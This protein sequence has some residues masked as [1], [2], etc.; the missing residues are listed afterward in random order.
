MLPFAGKRLVQKKSTGVSKDY[1]FRITTSNERPIKFPQNS[2]NNLE[3][4]WE[5]VDATMWIHTGIY[6]STRRSRIQSL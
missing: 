6:D 3:G 2:S 5:I 1:R 4:I